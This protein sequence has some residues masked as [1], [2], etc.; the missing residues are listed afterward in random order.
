MLSLVHAS[1]GALLAAVVFILRKFDP[2]LPRLRQLDTI[3]GW[4]HRHRIQKDRYNM[5]VYLFGVVFQ[6]H[7]KCA[8]A[9]WCHPNALNADIVFVVVEKVKNDRDLNPGPPGY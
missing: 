7:V 2:F 4:I 6:D 3:H 1:Y 5:L 9:T 8:C